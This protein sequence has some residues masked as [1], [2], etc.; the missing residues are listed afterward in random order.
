MGLAPFELVFR[1]KLRGVMQTLREEWVSPA[2]R[3]GQRPTTYMSQLRER[4]DWTQKQAQGQ[5]QLAQ[6]KQKQLYDQTA[7]YRQLQVRE[8]VLVRSH[9]FPKASSHK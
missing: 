8:Q 7:R 3:A 1:R 2:H 6:T 5:L 4:L 9:L